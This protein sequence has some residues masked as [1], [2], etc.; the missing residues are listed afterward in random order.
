MYNYR[1]LKCD[2]QLMV[3]FVF[4]LLEKHVDAESMYIQ[5]RHAFCPA[6]HSDVI[7]QD[8][9][10]KARLKALEKTVAELQAKK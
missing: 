5:R 9:D 8:N 4:A 3:C 6:L 1:P 10:I 2:G 7:L